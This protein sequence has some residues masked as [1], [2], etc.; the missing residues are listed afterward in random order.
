MVAAVK[1]DGDAVNVALT[2]RPQRPNSASRDGWSGLHHPS[3]PRRTC[4]GEHLTTPFSGLRERGGRVSPSVQA[5]P[6]AVGN[7]LARPQLHELC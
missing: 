1:V 2:R 7:L 3:R 6:V 4:Q 5:L